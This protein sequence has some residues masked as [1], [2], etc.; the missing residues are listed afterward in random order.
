[1]EDN[2]SPTGSCWPLCLSCLSAK[3]AAIKQQRFDVFEN[4]LIPKRLSKVDAGVSSVS[5]SVSAQRR[6]VCWREVEFKPDFCWDLFRKL[7]FKVDVQGSAA[8]VSSAAQSAFIMHGICRPNPVFQPCAAAFPAS[9]ERM[10]HTTST[11]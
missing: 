6:Q 3:L 10:S 5:C 7:I 8:L 11:T 2:P 9:T 4:N 1:M